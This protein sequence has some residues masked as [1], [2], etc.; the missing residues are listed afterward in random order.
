MIYE[1]P[2]IINKVSSSEDEGVEVRGIMLSDNKG[3]VGL[4]ASRIVSIK[5]LKKDIKLVGPPNI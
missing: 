4:Y 3:D 2:F 5:N 1:K